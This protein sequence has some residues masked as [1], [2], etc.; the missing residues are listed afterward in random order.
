MSTNLQGGEERGGPTSHLDVPRHVEQVEQDGFTLVENPFG[1]ERIDALEETVRR[2]QRE[3][4]ASEVGNNPFYGYKT[5]RTEGL[6]DYD[7]VFEQLAIHPSLLAIV[8]GLLGRDCLLGSTQAITIGPGEEAQEIHA[9]RTHPPL[10]LMDAPAG[11]HVRTALDCMICLTDFTDA[12]GATRLVPRSHEQGIPTDDKAQRAIPAEASRG[13]LVI[14]D[15]ATWH[16]GGANRTDTSRIGLLFYY[17]VGWTRPDDNLL[18][19]L[20]RE[21]IKRF[22]R[23][24]QELVGVSEYLNFL[25]R[26]AGRPALSAL[27]PDGHYPKESQDPELTGGIVMSNQGKIE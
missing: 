18:L 4:P 20:S 8:E 16:G 3:D 22:P 13:D 9:D 2:I 14:W 12:N 27:D 6:I 17:V 24:L 1:L 23:R 11:T 19:L 21:K 7:E 15:A 25:G 26:V 5:L 10:S